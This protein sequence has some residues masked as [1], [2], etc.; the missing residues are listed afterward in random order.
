MK[1]ST[2][3]QIPEVKNNKKTQ[4]NVSSLYYNDFQM[5]NVEHS[6][7]ILCEYDNV[8]NCCMLCEIFE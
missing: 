7:D 4:L 2:F 1:S 6:L 5:H 3:G 8:F